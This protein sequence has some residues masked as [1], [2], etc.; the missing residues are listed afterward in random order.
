[1]LNSDQE[2]V[3][4]GT[5]RQISFSNLSTGKYTLMIRVAEDVDWIDNGI[6]SIHIKVLPPFWRS[7]TA[8]VVYIIFF[9]MCFVY[10]YRRTVLKRNAERLLL[11]R[12][13][14]TERMREINQLKMNFFT[15]I[16]HELNT[17]LTLIISPIQ[18]M[19]AQFSLLPEVKDKMLMVKRNA[20]RMKYLVEELILLGKMESD[21]RKIL[22]EEGFA[23]RFILELSNGFKPWAEIKNIHYSVDI[24]VSKFPV[25]F[26]SS[27]IE[28]IV[29]NLL[30]NAFKFTEP[31]GEVKLTAEY[32]FEN[33]IKM[34]RI[35]V[36]DTG[37]GI[38]AKDLDKI[39]EKY[40]QTN[41]R[42]NNNGFGIGLS[43]VKQLSAA[44]KGS[45]GVQS[46]YGKG[47]TFTVILAVDEKAFDDNEKS[48]C[49]FDNEQINNYQYLIPEVVEDELINQPPAVKTEK[50]RE[51]RPL[52][53]IVEDN[54]DLR[55]FIG[56]IFDKEYRI[57]LCKNGKDAY[58]QALENI[59]DLIISDLMMPEMDGLDLC[60]QIKTSIETCHIPF[61]MLTAKVDEQ[62]VIEGYEY[63]ADHYVKK[64]FST[65][66][67]SRQVKNILATQENQRTYF[68]EN[69]DFIQ[70]SSKVNNKDKKLLE[71]V[72]QHIMDH[73]S[74]ENYSVV[75]L[76]K[77]VGVS[78]TLL[79]IKLKSVVGMSATEYINKIKMQEGLRLL[80]EGNNISEVSYITG[81]GSPSYF[82]RC[83]K[84]VYGRSPHDF[85]KNNQK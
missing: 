11:E 83:F 80:Q 49:K 14:E 53:L 24:N 74:D 51:N 70:E 78:R 42:G 72:N 12:K 27:K 37:R 45:V 44:H 59:P 64:P 3:N 69:P 43:L 19:L 39:F 23:L 63:G 8:Y 68:R 31:Q 58:V 52:L 5:Q 56:S 20:E 6:R 13:N 50:I 9:L 75:H 30:S 67:L 57:I 41:N 46:E 55:E 28:K 77:D 25:Y 85:M 15:N 33:D 84:K 48:S 47:S 29:Y 7:T 81:F 2:W 18:N 10:Y 26:D 54:H 38:A 82:S 73:L 22:V 32:F 34:L 16:S 40:Y 1:M 4:L 76:T 35:I 21:S 36:S 65:A 79:H 71:L 17:P 60:K 61:I 66:I 62:H